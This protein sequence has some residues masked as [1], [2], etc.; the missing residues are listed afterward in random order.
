M[1]LFPDAESKARPG[2]GISRGSQGHSGLLTLSQLSH[3]LWTWSLGSKDCLVLQQ[4]PTVRTWNYIQHLVMS[5]NG[6]ESERVYIHTY[7]HIYVFSGGAS[8]K[9]PAHQCIDMRDVGSI[10][11]SEGS[12]GGRRGNPL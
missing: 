12:S 6:K 9:E 1:W 7:T 11:G 10:L 3:G 2:A 8:G 5:Y 4:G